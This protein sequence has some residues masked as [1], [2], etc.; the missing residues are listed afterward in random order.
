MCIDASKRPVDAY[1]INSLDLRPDIDSLSQVSSDLDTL[2]KML[3][4]A[5]GSI[6]EHI[7][8]L[9]LKLY[10]RFSEVS[11]R[12]RLLQCLGRNEEVFKPSRANTCMQ[13]SC[14]VL[15]RRC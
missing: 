14:S 13:V 15:S 7:Y 3:T 8:T 2:Y 6:T 1:L 12:S 11:L 10:N 9:F 4:L 5:Q